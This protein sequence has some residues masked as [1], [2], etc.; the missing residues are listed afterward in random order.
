MENREYYNKLQIMV[1][2]AKELKSKIDLISDYETK[3]YL[4]LAL[5]TIYTD[6]RELI[7][8]KNNN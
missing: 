8:E 1:N 2:K 6:M 3:S 5:E 7:K 4:K